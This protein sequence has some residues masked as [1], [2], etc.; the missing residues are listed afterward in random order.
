MDEIKR[1]SEILRK[2]AEE[3]ISS[4]TSEETTDRVKKVF[5]RRD[6][7]IRK[8]RNYQDKTGMPNDDEADKHFIE[9]ETNVKYSDF[10]DAEEN[11]EVS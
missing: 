6:G 7:A 10:K 4:E 9:N 11:N 3:K 1:Q 2:R 8:I 5:D